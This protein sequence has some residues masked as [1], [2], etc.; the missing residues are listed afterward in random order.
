MN[1]KIIWIVGVVVLVA[2]VVGVYAFNNR[3]AAPAESLVSAE[4]SSLSP[5]PIANLMNRKLPVSVRTD[6]LKDILGKAEQKQLET[7]FLEKNKSALFS[8]I[9]LDEMLEVRTLAVSFM[10]RIYASVGMKDPKTDS[11]SLFDAV[12]NLLNK[13]ADQVS[14]ASL[15]VLYGSMANMNLERSKDEIIKFSS[16]YKD[17]WQK[18]PITLMNALYILKRNSEITKNQKLIDGIAFVCAHKELADI[19]DTV[20]NTDVRMLFGKLCN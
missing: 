13:D 2:A 9:S 17:H 16:A 4:T 10:P 6:I 12:S 5:D 20:N 19:K 3:S 15:G 8:L 18:R 14:F 7:S 11:S 1:K